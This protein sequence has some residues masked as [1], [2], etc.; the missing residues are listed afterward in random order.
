MGERGPD[1]KTRPARIALIDAMEKL[2]QDPVKAYYVRAEQHNDFAKAF[3]TADSRF[4]SFLNSFRRLP[5]ARVILYR[6][7]RNAFELFDGNVEDAAP[8]AE[9]VSQTIHR[10]AP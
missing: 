8:V 1:S 10:G 4:S 3:E 5:A 2:K 6:P 9:F 7:K